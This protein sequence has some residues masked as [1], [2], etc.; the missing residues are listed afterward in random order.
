MRQILTVKDIKK[1]YGRFEAV[2][3]ISFEVNENEIF[4]LIGPNGAGKTST[5]RIIATILQPTSGTADINGI[6]IVKTPREARSLISYLPEE[7]G[8]Y[9]NMT[10][11]KY[12]RFM[13]E[14]FSANRQAQ[15]TFI[16][17]AREITGL[18]ERLNDKIASYSK[19]MTRKLLLARAL[20]TRPK[21]AILDEPTS[22][23]DVINALDI[24]KTIKDFAKTGMAVLLSSHNMLEIEYLSDRVGI[25]DKGYIH[26]IGTPEELKAKYVS[27]NLEEVFAKVAQ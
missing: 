1:S 17:T 3:G 19:G 8:A 4:A 22:G 2:K 15:E 16:Q 26:E 11:I 6:D 24:R 5:L 18:G 10:G 13:G 27:S 12:L 14:L 25:I 7:A 20:M 9:K 21:L 23:L